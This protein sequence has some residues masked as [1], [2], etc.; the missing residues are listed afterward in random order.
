MI[1]D[2]KNYLVSVCSQLRIEPMKERE[3]IREIYLHI[4]DRINDLK[5][6]GMSEDEADKEAVN[7][8]GPPRSIA[9]ELNY[10]YGGGNWWQASGAAMPHL[11]LAL[12][13]GLH[14]WRDVRWLSVAMLA[15][16]IVSIWGWRR[17]KPAWFFSWLGYPLI[18]LLGIGILCLYLLQGNGLQNS[19]WAWFALIAF[20]PF[21]LRLLLPVTRQAVKRDW[22]L[23]SLM[24]LPLPGLVGWVLNVGKE[25]WLS[26]I[27]NR[28]LKDVDLWVS[29]SFFIL[30]ITSVFFIRFKER[31]LKTAAIVINALLF[32]PILAHFNSSMTIFGL[33]FV[34]IL[35]TLSILVLPAIAERRLG[36]GEPENILPEL[37]LLNETFHRD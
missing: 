19:W 30:A 31:T 35:T 21:V 16:L 37:N 29:F 3:V 32:I 9:G 7:S 20:I 17:G 4:V 10:I 22:L 23:A 12:L 1:S 26:H 14:L 33:L 28:A 5:A 27:N 13:F 34:I 18:T 15:L 36:H 24:F 25:G 6:S 11:I 8:L 2:I